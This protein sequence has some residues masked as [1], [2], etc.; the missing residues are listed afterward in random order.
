VI[1]IAVFRERR[2]PIAI[3]R[4]PG[5]IASAK[6]RAAQERDAPAANAEPSARDEA[7][8]ERRDGLARA[9]IP[10]PALG[11]GHGRIESSHAERTT[12]ERATAS[13]AD[14]I[15]IRYDRRENLAALGI[16]TPPAIARQ[17]DP[18]PGA[19]RFTPDPPR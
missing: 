2:E 13:P 16:L 8:G 17:P 18:F 5:K 15:T 14:T 12:F 3:D 10:A 1:G 6:E 4:P 11:T 7:A 9:P 19:M